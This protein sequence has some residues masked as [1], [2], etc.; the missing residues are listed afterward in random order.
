[1][2]VHQRYC[3]IAFELCPDSV[4]ML[5]Y[6]FGGVQSIQA[7][8]LLRGC[9]RTSC[10][11]SI[12]FTGWCSKLYGQAVRRRA[13]TYFCNGI[14]QIVFDFS[15]L[16]PRLLLTTFARTRA[17]S[18][19]LFQEKVGLERFVNICVHGLLDFSDWDHKVDFA[20]SYCR[21]IQSRLDRAAGKIRS[22]LLML[23]C[24][25]SSVLMIF[26]RLWRQT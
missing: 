22:H 19:L 25:Y 1:M 2:Y 26:F 24:F 23:L 9:T 21:Y 4:D 16:R 7:P 13:A 10:L 20:I 15:F 8:I 18:L 3:H 14:T 12:I 11:L 6:H 5:R 17:T